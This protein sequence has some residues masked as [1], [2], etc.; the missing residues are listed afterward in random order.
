MLTDSATLFD[1]ITRHRRTS[2]GRLMLD[3]YAAREAY[4]NRE[5]DNICLI[6]SEYN[7]ADAMTKAPGNSALLKTI[8]THFIYHP[9]VQY[10][11]SCNKRCTYEAPYSDQHG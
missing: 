7:V 2:E 10:V 4:R 3:I 11:I 5:M 1:A 6:R 8:Q 9:V